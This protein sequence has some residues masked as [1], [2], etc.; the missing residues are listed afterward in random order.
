[1]ERDS[2]IVAPFIERAD[3]AAK[4]YVNGKGEKTYNGLKEHISEQ[5]S[6]SPLSSKQKIDITD[7]IAEDYRHMMEAI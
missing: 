7:I 5:L 2:M 4:E 3:L 1:M 6:D